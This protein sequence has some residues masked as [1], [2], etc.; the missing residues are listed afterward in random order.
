MDKNEIEILI[1]VLRALPKESEWVEFKVNNSNPQIIGEYI[2]A[3]SNSAN[4]ENKEYAYL[5]FGIEDETHKIIGTSFHPRNKKVGNQEIENWLITQLEPKIDFKIIEHSINDKN[6]VLFQI[7]ASQ[8][9]PV[10]FKGV[11]YIRVGSYKKKLK[12]HPEKERKIW[13][14]AKSI[15]FEKEIAVK[16]ISSDKV[17]ELLDYP[18]VFK[19]LQ[20]SLPSNKNGIL[21]KLEEEKLIIKRLNKYNI[22]NIGAL[23]F[24]NDL[25]DFETLK[26]K[27]IR[28]VIYKGKNK[29]HTIKEYQSNLG[30]AVGFKQLVEYV[31]D[32]LP[33][34]EEIGKVFRKEVKMFPELA[35]R[36]LIAN[37]II[38]Q[39]F[40]IS[41]TSTMIEIFENRIEFTKP[42][43]PLIDTKR[44]IDHSPESRNEMLASLMRRMNFCE[45]RGSGI[46]KVIHEIELYQLPAPE[47]LSGDNY[48]RVILYSPKSLR[49]MSKPDKVRACYQHACLKYVSGEYMTNQSFR[50]RLNIDKKNYSI[51]SRIIKEAIEIG[52]IIEYENSRMYVPFWAN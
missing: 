35:V 47:F 46:D 45:E 18:S 25:N 13:Q 49:Q 31:N 24:A 8:N 30:Y 33:S 21:E 48:T 12:E 22:T 37:A 36:E 29:L 28:V 16:N 52:V 51:V 27:A 40:N 4:L 10:A 41:G 42:G 5:V 1:D 38:H 15:S 11:E 7:E 2:S 23:L 39:D 14:K 19:L 50:E 6:I 20:I 34:N 9:R 32:K 44:F 26:R 3:L 43:K 17:L